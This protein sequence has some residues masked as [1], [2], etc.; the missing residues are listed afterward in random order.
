L[1]LNAFFLSLAFGVT[2]ALTAGAASSADPAARELQRHQLQREQQQDELQL[3]MLQQQREAQ[4]PSPAARELEIDQR[5]RQQQLHY[6]QQIAPPAGQPSDDAGTQR[7][8][9]QM[10]EERA[11]QERARELQRFDSELRQ[12]R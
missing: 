9:A 7:A 5:R 11:R 1:I 4:R 8:R 2:A 12:A 6:Q 10:D 3:R